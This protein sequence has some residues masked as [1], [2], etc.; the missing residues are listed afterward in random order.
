M[1]IKKLANT[2]DWK[3]YCEKSIEVYREQSEG[4]YKAV[5]APIYSFLPVL[6]EELKLLKL[7]QPA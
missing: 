5:F 2:H 6:Y 3:S 4:K 7:D 1:V